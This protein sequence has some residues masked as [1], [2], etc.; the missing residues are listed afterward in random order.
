MNKIIYIGMDVHS[1]NFTLCS[2]EPGYDMAL[3]QIRSLDKHR[4]KKTYLTVL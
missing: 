2:F 3:R 1:T 4:L